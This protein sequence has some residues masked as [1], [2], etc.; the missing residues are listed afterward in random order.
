[1]DALENINEVRE[2]LRPKTPAEITRE[3]GIENA[4]RL[5]EL[6]KAKQQNE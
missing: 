2:C 5:E 3:L 1:V 6:R 4:K